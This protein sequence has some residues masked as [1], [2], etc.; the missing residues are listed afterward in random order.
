VPEYVPPDPFQVKGRAFFNKPFFNV[1]LSTNIAVYKHLAS[2][3]FEGDMERVVWASTDMMFRKRQ[4]QI[5]K[6]K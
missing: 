3:Y 2:L 1:I 5:A 6:R 4:E